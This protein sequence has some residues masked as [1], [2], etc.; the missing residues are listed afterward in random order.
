MGGHGY[1][2]QVSVQRQGLAA[3]RHQVQIGHGVE[4]RRDQQGGADHHLHRAHRQAQHDGRADHRAED[5]GGDAGDQQDGI[6]LDQMH[7][8][9]PLGHRGQAVARVQHGGQEAVGN[10]LP[11]PQPSGGRGEGAYAQGVEEIGHGADGHALGLGF[12]L[13][14]NTRRAHQLDCVDGGQDGQHR[15]QDGQDHDVSLPRGLAALAG[16]SEA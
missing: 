9:Q 5:G 7:E 14:A 6:H 11:E 16:R 1:D 2:E 13:A 8:D 4:P 10:Q 15:Q 12:K 3:G